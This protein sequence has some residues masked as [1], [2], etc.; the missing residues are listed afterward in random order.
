MADS[1]GPGLKNS[2]CSCS[3][4]NIILILAIIGTQDMFFDSKSVPS[5]QKE[6]CLVFCLFSCRE[7]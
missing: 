7:G 6:F 5:L 2:D 4:V 1:L 3:A